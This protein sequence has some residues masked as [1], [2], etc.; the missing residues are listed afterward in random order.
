MKQF[1]QQNSILQDTLV[2]LE[3]MKQ[4][5]QQNSNLRDT[6]VRLEIM[7]QLEQQIARYFNMV[8]NYLLYRK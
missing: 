2:R 5:E 3:I 1:E 4:L 7:K 8:R 6:L